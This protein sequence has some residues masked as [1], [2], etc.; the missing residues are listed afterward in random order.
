MFKKKE[1]YRNG[2]DDLAK[3]AQEH[4]E[5]RAMATRKLLRTLEKMKAQQD[6]EELGRRQQYGRE[7]GAL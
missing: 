7:S 4:S 5:L 1:P 2:L 6:E 3:M